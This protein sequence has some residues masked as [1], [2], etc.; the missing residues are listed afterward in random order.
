[1]RELIRAPSPNSA[2]DAEDLLQGMYYLDQVG[3]VGH[4]LVDVL[5]GAGDFVEHAFVLAAD[6]AFGLPLQILDGKC[7]LR[8]VAAHPAAGAVRAGV[9]A[10]GVALAAHD[11]AARA[12]S[13]ANEAKLAC[14]GPNRTFTRDHH[15][16]A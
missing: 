12:L 8:C 10:L 5:V 6:D 1:M 4:H 13:A 16:R 2:F 15:R 11:V 7:L 3:L 14:P 9:E